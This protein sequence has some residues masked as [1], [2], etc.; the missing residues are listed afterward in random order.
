LTKEQMEVLVK[1]QRGQSEIGRAEQEGLLPDVNERLDHWTQEDYL[2]HA[3]RMNDLGMY[4]A[5]MWLRREADG[6]HVSWTNRPR[7]ARK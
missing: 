5:E 7:K 4:G 3:D 2:V 1:G 6:D